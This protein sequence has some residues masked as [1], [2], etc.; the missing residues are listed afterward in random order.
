M[1]IEPAAEFATLHEII[2]AARNNLTQGVWDYVTG[3]TDSETTLRRNRQALDSIALR[4]RV[5]RDV[6]KRSAKASFMG[7]DLSMPIILAPIGS[8]QMVHEGGAATSAKAA[9]IANVIHMVSSRSGP[10]LEET[11]AAADNH[12][13]FQLYIR[14][15]DKFEDDH[16]KRAI[17][18]GYFAFAI[19]V[20]LDYYTRRERDHANRFVH[21]SRA[22]M[23]GGGMEFQAAYSWDSVK[24]FKDKHDIP[25]IL[26]GIGTV[27]DAVTAVEHGAEAVYLS[28]HGGRGLDSGRGAIE[29][30]RET[31]PEI[32]GK[33]K[34]IYDGGV[35]RGTDV[36]KAMILGADA[37]GIGRM[38]CLGMAAAGVPGLLRALEIL[39]EE[40]HIAFGLMGVN[41]WDEL[42]DSFICDAEPVGEPHIF[43]QHP[44]VVFEPHLY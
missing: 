6:S 39:D 17:D 21:L 9:E 10:G 5:M 37:V 44:M 3:A 16:V 40:I 13:I 25:L 11:A 32:K 12:R 22:V 19:T 41:S 4:P 20:D 29:I 1:S 33:A 35:M 38:Q 23:A 36:V 18:N 24:R 34:I 15:D 43:S 42:D 2:K 26:K 28:N 8:L 7:H 30:L 14:G 27:E 31:A